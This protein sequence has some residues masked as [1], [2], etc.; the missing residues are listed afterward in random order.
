MRI[1]VLSNLY[2][3]PA[4][5]AFGTF[6]AAR[7]DALRAAGAHV[8]V[9][10][11]SDPAVGR[12]VVMKYAS[13]GARSV[14]YTALRRVRRP[15][16]DIVEAHIAFPTGLV[17]R[18]VAALLGAPLVLFAHGADVLEV[19]W[20][21]R[22]HEVL[23]RR[24]YA[25]ARLVIAN[26]EFLAGELRRVFPA[27]T[28]KI[29]VMSPGIE[30]ARFQGS[31]AATRGSRGLL[32]V[33]RLVPAKGGAILLRALAGLPPASRPAPV[34]FI[35]DGP[36]RDLLK[37]LARDLGLAVTFAGEAGRDAVAEAMR[38]SAIVAVP[39][40]HQ[41]PLGL[42]ALEA[43][44]AGAIVVAS[45]TGGLQEIVDDGVNGLTVPPDDVAAL[46]AAI[47]RAKSIAADGVEGARVRNAA[48]LTAQAH[49][50]GQV[51]AAS[52]RLY[53]TLKA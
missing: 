9:V 53:G 13:L 44:A 32:F 31:D 49:D 52:L 29:V 41:E 43:M 2:P 5:P 46:S 36:E 14:A 34:T 45:A 10:A 51:V 8:D 23:A 18:P 33:G 6:I 37:A 35:G 15:K 7:V 12:R 30:L 4:H 25:A 1:L 24:T 50:I 11:V 19:P 20:R 40:V 16:V 3:S 47:L 48:S 26:S 42:A 28:D 39:S 17:A 38:A 22:R 27:L 21:S